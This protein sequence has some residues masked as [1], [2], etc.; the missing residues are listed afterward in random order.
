MKTVFFV[1][2]TRYDDGNRSQAMLW[3]DSSGAIE[4]IGGETKFKHKS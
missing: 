1:D 2:T 4:K 3:D